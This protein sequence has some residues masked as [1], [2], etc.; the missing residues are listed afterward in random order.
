MCS[1]LEY[2]CRKY[3]PL[4]P[5]P[6][7]TC[8]PRLLCLPLGPPPSHRDAVLGLFSLRPYGTNTPPK[9]QALHTVEVVPCHREPSH[10]LS[11]LP[12]TT[13][14]PPVA[15]VVMGL[16]P[17]RALPPICP[18]VPP[19]YLPLSVGEHPSPPTTPYTS[20]RTLLLMF[21]VT[22]PT[23]SSIR[24]RSQV[25]YHRL[26]RWFG[27]T[28]TLP[29]RPRYPL[30]GSLTGTLTLICMCLSSEFLDKLLKILGMWHS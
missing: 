27:I 8:T 16:F 30:P 11:Y 13:G 10:H 21:P 2:G 9:Q 23:L 22:R 15:M 25:L 28:Q 7:P 29:R 26:T 12:L 17:P 19:E 14:R 1:R 5:L 4:R 18:M 20:D 3:P 6:C 24:N